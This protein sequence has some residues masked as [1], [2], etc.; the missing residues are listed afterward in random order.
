MRFSKRDSLINLRRAEP[1]R[2]GACGTRSPQRM[3]VEHQP[4]S[5]SGR[6]AI[7]HQDDRPI[8]F[9]EPTHQAT[10][11]VGIVD[12]PNGGRRESTGLRGRH[13]RDRKEKGDDAETDRL[14]REVAKLASELGLEHGL[15]VEPPRGT[16]GVPSATSKS[17]AALQRDALPSQTSTRPSRLRVRTS[18]TRSVRPRS[19]TS[20]GTTSAASPTSRT[21]SPRRSSCRSSGPSSSRAA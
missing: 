12:I 14:A 20:R 18:P 10:A 4:E 7:H 13:S 16:N 11:V 21:P 1:K 17:P 5:V 15:G 19:P 6:I 2:Q 3:A 9:S 8:A